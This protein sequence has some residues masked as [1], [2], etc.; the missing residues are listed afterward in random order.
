MVK[1][2]QNRT[3]V[4][5]RPVP[6]LEVCQCLPVRAITGLVEGG[7]DPSRQQPT[8]GQA[9]TQT[10]SKGGKWQGYSPQ[11]RLRHT[12][13]S[14]QNF[15][16]KS[17]IIIVYHKVPTILCRHHQKPSGR[18]HS[19][20]P[21]ICHFILTWPRHI[22]QYQSKVSTIKSSEV[23]MH[24]VHTDH[25]TLF[26]QT[27]IQICIRRWLEIGVIFEFCDTRGIL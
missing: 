2:Q 7:V 27:Y 5:T 6:W 18:R 13:N 15:P 11:G 22:H 23:K 24:F 19:R 9:H 4:M 17:V 25:F 14:I 8:A 10:S 16:L 20:T 3:G 1:G 21:T 12:F 26:S